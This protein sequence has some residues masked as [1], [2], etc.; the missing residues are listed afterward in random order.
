LEINENTAQLEYLN[1]LA[2]Q[3]PNIAAASEEIINL[4]AILNL[5]KGTEHYLSDV[6]GEY[7]AFEHILKSGSGLIKRKIDDI[8]TSTLLEEEKKEL[9]S[10]IF[11]PEKKIKLGLSQVNDKS[12]WIRILLYRMIKM[13]RVLGSKYTR[14]YVR[15]S[16]P[17]D[18]AYIIEELLYEQE[19]VFNKQNYYSNIIE[20]IIDVGRGEAFLIAMAGLIQKL[21]IEK[22]HVIGDIYDRGPGA[23]KILDTL[24]SYHSVDIQWGNHDILWMGA[25]AG[26]DACIA[27]VIRISL[28]YTNTGTL[29]D[30]YGVS[31]LP[32][33]T[34]AMEVYKNDDCE[35]FTPQVSDEKVFSQQEL[36]LIG[37]MQKAIAVI[38]FKLEGQVIQRRPHYGMADRRL[39]HRINYQEGT[40]DYFGKELP[41]KDDNFP[42]INPKD[43]YSLS[44]M[45]KALMKRLRL[46]FLNSEKLQSHVRFLFSRGSMYKVSNNQLL[47]HGCISLDEKGDFD[48]FQ[49]D[50][51]EYVGKAFMDRVEKLARQGYFS[52]EPE[53]RLYGM[54]A[55]W[56]LWSGDKSPIFGKSKMATFERYFL[57]D[58]E[59]HKEHKNH[60]YT[61]RDKQETAEKILKEFG[62]DPD[63]THIINGHV[64]VQVK[65]GESPVKAGGKLL[66]IDG[67]F[68]RAYQKET[69]IAGY[70]LIFNSYGLLLAEH[71]PFISVQAAV[72]EGEDMHSTTHIL[73][74]NYNRLWVKDTDKGKR[75]QKRIESLKNLMKAFRSGEIKER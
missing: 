22:L 12:G 26:S 18:F 70:T 72:E 75:I 28:R 62:L 47:Y 48:A 66:V 5:P 51:K 43:P 63:R 3:Y 13:C 25:A 10:I 24:M 73:E 19:G 40:I 17:R 44:P 4:T 6:H 21:A 34:F 68:S 8:F 53:E 31:L 9:A 55:M 30:G 37:K 33:A 7:K 60:Y 20:T 50:G 27:N 49:V 41:L 57:A 64:P 59:T 74:A 71:K 29:E 16:L 11:Y 56:Y 35:L 1:L 58:K 67:G 23:H 46:S 38:Q 42:T 2:N 39:L 61:F 45:E 32:L 54:D 52:R 15:K 69:G 36:K 14:S 65:K